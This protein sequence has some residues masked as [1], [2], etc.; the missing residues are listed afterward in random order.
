[1]E[2]F[3]DVRSPGHRSLLCVVVVMMCLVGAPLAAASVYTVSGTSDPSPTPLCSGTVCP[4]LR[5]AVAA[6]NANPGSTVQLGRATYTLSQGTSLQPV[7]NVTIAGDGPSATTIVQTGMDRVIF[8][9]VPNR[10]VD[11]SGLTITGGDLVGTTGASGAN[12]GSVLG[13]GVLN[14]G[15]MTLTDVAL[16]GN[17]TTGGAGGAGGSGGDGGFALGAAVATG[18]QTADPS[19]LTLV[20]TTVTSDIARGGDGGS[21]TSGL[22]GSG[23]VT[24]AVIYGNQFSTIALRNSA[25]SD[26]EAVGGGGGLGDAF[27]QGA[28]SGGGADGGIVADGKLGV[29]NSTIAGNAA[30]GGRGGFAFGN[31]NGGAGGVADGGGILVSHSST[32]A[33]TGS[34]VDN[35]TATGG[36]GAISNG[37]GDGGAGGAAHGG[38]IDSASVNESLVVN[39][40]ISGNTAVGGAGGAGAVDGSQG[41]GEGG[42][43]RTQG[44][45]LANVTVAGDSADGGTATG[46]GNL[47]GGPNTLSDTIIAGGSTNG[48]G[49]NCDLTTASADNGHNSEDTTPSQC[50]LSAGNADQIGLDVKLLAL[51][52]NGGPTQT[53]ALAAGSPALGTGGACMDPSQIGNPPLLADQR[54]LPR[55]AGGCDIGAFQ[56]QPPGAAGAPQ[57]TGTPTVGQ[58]LT[59]SQGAWTGDQLS[60]SYRWQ[61]DGLPISGTTATTYIVASTD[62]DHQLACQVT[63]SNVKGTT[64]QTSGSANVPS[65]G[66][67]GGGA[68]EGLRPPSPEL[69]NPILCGLRATSS[70]SYPG[71]AGT[72]SARYLASRLTKPP[73]SA[74]RSCEPHPDARSVNAASRPRKATESR[75]RARDSSRMA[76]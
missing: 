55:P 57:I 29:V 33:M 24:E 5:A 75:A 32:L 67:G 30:T 1:M 7:V 40:T 4:S 46:G 43:I 9:G 35:N 58:P 53:L 76:R 12:G 20:D 22:G 66:S 52:S 63:A 72:P 64:S 11:V 25:V 23:G 26:N 54:G 10:V 42:G 37:A 59:C 62:S 45:T 13:G 27:A 17:R 21:A 41:A 69:T 65:A 73:Q 2:E 51:A 48:S 49:G 31:F 71:R 60:F 74:S 44:M 28:G 61:R 38:G 19:S 15:T 6:A 68:A 36:Q 34:T 3:F 14:Y 47:Y 16:T 56:F 70:R 39:S 18:D 8:A 50:G